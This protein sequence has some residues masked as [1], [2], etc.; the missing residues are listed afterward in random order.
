VCLPSQNPYACLAWSHCCFSSFCLQTRAAEHR[1]RLHSLSAKVCPDH[2][3]TRRDQ[4]CKLK[5]RHSPLRPL[6]RAA[7]NGLDRSQQ[8]PAA[9]L[10][11]GGVIACVPLSNRTGSLAGNLAAKVNFPAMSRQTLCQDLRGLQISDS[12]TSTILWPDLPDKTEASQQHAFCA[13]PFTLRALDCAVDLA[14]LLRMLSDGACSG[15][16]LS[17]FMHHCMTVYTHLGDPLYFMCGAPFDQVLL[18][19]LPPTAC[20]LRCKSVLSG[21]QTTALLSPGLD[22][23]WSI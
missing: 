15:I 1:C 7:A 18:F 14:G 8:R 21:T 22:A 11:G 20:R 13:R 3:L 23:T 9:S 16:H 10:S 2:A 19:D 5:S 17:T 12:D 6:C 4:P